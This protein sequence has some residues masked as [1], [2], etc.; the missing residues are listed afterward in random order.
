[1]NQLELAVLSAVLEHQTGEDIVGIITEERLHEALTTGPEFSAEERR[2]LWFSPDVRE[3]YF[4]VR[5]SLDREMRDDL[6]VNGYGHEQRLR[7]ASSSTD[8]EFIEGQGYRLSIFRDLIGD[9]TEWTLS[10]QL[11]ETFRSRL[12]ARTVVRFYD[13]GGVTW[14]K[15]IPDEMGQ[16]GAVWEHEESPMER[17]SKYGLSLGI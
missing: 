15:G 13:S 9:Q 8:V 12:F 3:T 11:E 14:V 17:A 10:L 4:T 7:T 5:E 6:V 1:M 2:L 16:I